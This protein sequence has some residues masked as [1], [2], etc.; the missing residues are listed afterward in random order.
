MYANLSD[1]IGSTFRGKVFLDV[2][3][4]TAALIISILK[5]SEGVRNRVRYIKSY[6]RNSN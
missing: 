5:E 3:C 6:G 4:G 1:Y 2:G